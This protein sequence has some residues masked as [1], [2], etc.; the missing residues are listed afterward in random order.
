VMAPA[1]APGAAPSIAP[2]PAPAAMTVQTSA[3]PPLTPSE[4]ATSNIEVQSGETMIDAHGNV[5]PKPATT[6]HLWL[7]LA[8]GAAVYLGS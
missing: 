5:V 1:P 8:A 3:S 4:L 2:A 6:N 7:L